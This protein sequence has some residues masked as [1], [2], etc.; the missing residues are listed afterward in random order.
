MGREGE[1]ESNMY[2]LTKIVFDKRIASL[3]LIYVRFDLN[4]EN[5]GDGDVGEKGDGGNEGVLGA[6]AIGGAGI[7]SL[8]TFYFNLSSSSLSES[9]A[10]N[11]C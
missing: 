8:I 6:F 2:S 4:L 9:L 5:Q 1:G 7:A 10:C 3:I 11:I